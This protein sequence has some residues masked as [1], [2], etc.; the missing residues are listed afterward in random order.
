MAQQK[1][2]YIHAPYDERKFAE[3]SPFYGASYH[4]LKEH[5]NNRR[6]W[7]EGTSLM[8]G[9]FDK[10]QL[11]SVEYNLDHRALILRTV[12]ETAENLTL[13]KQKKLRRVSGRKMTGWVKPIIEVCNADVTNLFGAQERFRATVYRGM[14]VF[15]IHPEDQARFARETSL[16]TNVRN[17]KITEGVAFFGLGI[18][19]H[20]THHGFKAAGLTPS[21]RW[22]IEREKK[23]I[24]TAILNGE[25][26]YAQTRIFCG[27]IEEIEPQLI[28]PVNAFSFSMP[29]TNHSSH[30][31]AKKGLTCAED[32]DEVT[33]LFGTLAIIKAANPAIL[34]SENVPSAQD[35]VSYKLL[36]KELTRMGY[37]FK[38]MLLDNKQAGC[39]EIRKRYWFVAV[40]KGLSIDPEEL[41]PPNYPA[42]HH[43]V[44]DI[45]DKE[46]TQDWFPLTKLNTRQA[47][48]IA[49]GRNFSLNLVDG[50]SVQVGCL[51][52]GYWR[53]QISNPHM[54]DHQGNYRLFSKFE[55]ARL[56]RIPTS[57]V[58]IVSQTDAH[59]GLGQSVSYHQAMGCA[60]IAGTAAKQHAVAQGDNF[61]FSLCASPIS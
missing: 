58:N 9:G 44:G 34:I 49:E 11:Y 24:D 22:G 54:T 25:D 56:K 2:I 18:S 6:I 23:Y 59:E 37:R 33:A 13:L 51:P 61:S 4:E 53:H 15:T 3:R 52:R 12:E 14:I 42:D 50:K 43:C 8:R 27:N 39:L 32:G 30:G 60:W 20:A 46:S 29:C 48:N 57:L 5:R 41:T 28:E 45:L 26:M 7:L 40:S 21:L 19:T 10:G 55:H 36:R 31:K 1:D 47:K 38:E 16:T 35:S 17:G